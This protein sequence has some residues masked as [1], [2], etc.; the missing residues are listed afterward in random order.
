MSPQAVPRAATSGGSLPFRIRRDECALSS[1]RANGTSAG[2]SLCPRKNQKCYKLR[3]TDASLVS[4]P[5]S[6][7]SRAHSDPGSGHFRPGRR[8]LCGILESELITAIAEM[9]PRMRAAHDAVA[10]P[11]YLAARPHLL[12]R[13][14]RLPHPPT[15]SGRC[16]PAVRAIGGR[17]N[18][19]ESSPGI[20]LKTIR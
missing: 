19:E 17:G 16:Q 7:A 11:G 15:F 9:G 18:L 8:I 13:S 1:L 2:P 4:P 14:A 3:H 5:G 6:A 12:M 10:R 20:C